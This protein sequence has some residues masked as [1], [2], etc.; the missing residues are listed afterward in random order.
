MIPT[1]HNYQR[2]LKA[3][4]PTSIFPQLLLTLYH[5]PPA[6]TNFCLFLSPSTNF[7]QF[8][9][10]SHQR[11]PSFT[12]FINFYQFL[13]Y[14]TNFYQIF[15]NSKWFY[16]HC[17]KNVQIR[18]FFW[19]VFCCIWIIQEIQEYRKRTTRKNS[20]FEQFSFSV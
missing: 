6:F 8:F 4:L 5:F 12:T 14:F 9:T 17:V 13:F 18:S 3:F 1:N 20:V 10:T 19:S 16:F 7:Y 15:I 11:L 2:V